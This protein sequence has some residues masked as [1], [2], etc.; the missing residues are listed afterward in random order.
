M[1]GF[2]WFNRA[3]RG[4][5]TD[6]LGE[7]FAM[8][9]Q[10]HPREQG[11]GGYAERT[12]IPEQ[13]GQRKK[14]KSRQSA[15]DT[16]PGQNE[17]AR[18]KPHENQRHARIV[19]EHRAEGGGDSFAAVKTKLRRPD[20]PHDDREHRQGRKPPVRQIMGDEPDRERAFGKIS[21]QGEKKSAGAQNAADIFR[22]NTAAARL[23]DVPAGLPANEIITKSQTAEEITG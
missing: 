16:S 15:E 1:V 2:R 11:I 20:V 21:Q 6:F 5:M 13:G 4:K 7:I 3:A 14:R 18:G 19:H 22:A 8:R 17:R 12:L 23:P 10:D 9:E